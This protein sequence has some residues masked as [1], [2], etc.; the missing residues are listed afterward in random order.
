MSARRFAWGVAVFIATSELYAT[1]E[2]ADRTSADVGYMIA[3]AFMM[4]AGTTLCFC[5]GLLADTRRV[6]TKHPAP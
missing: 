6:E 1:I 3:W 2:Y 4:G 5:I